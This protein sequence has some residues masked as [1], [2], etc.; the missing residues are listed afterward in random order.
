MPAGTFAGRRNGDARAGS[1][2]EPVPLW[3]R[4]RGRPHVADVTL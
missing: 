4:A 3:E 2:C 1:D